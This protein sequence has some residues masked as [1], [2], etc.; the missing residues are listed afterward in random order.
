M[1]TSFFNRLNRL[2]LRRFVSKDIKSL[3]KKWS[4]TLYIFILFLWCCYST[5]V[6]IYTFTICFH[7]PN[8]K[9]KNHINIAAPYYIAYLPKNT[10]PQCRKCTPPKKNKSLSIDPPPYATKNGILKAQ[11]FWVQLSQQNHPKNQDFEGYFG[12]CSLRVNFH[13]KISIRGRGTPFQK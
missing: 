12:G 10:A 13:W 4:Q 9:K 3:C 8:Q 1:L 5:F 7:V 2:D 11:I 6:H